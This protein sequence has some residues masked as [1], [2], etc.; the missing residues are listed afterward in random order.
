M[1]PTYNF[2]RY[3]NIRS[4]YTPT[5]L[6][7]GQRVAFLTDITGTP[8]VWSVDKDGGWPEQLTFFQEN[9]WT[10]GAAPDGNSLICS[11]DIGG[12]ENYQLYLVSSE[13]AEVRRITQNLDAIYHF[14]AW[15]PDG[16]HIAFSSNERDGL[17]FDVYIQD[18]EGDYPEIVYQSEGS[19]RVLTWS[20]EGR[21]LVLCNEISSANQPLHLLDLK[22]REVR[23][24]SP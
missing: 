23:Q 11:R 14:G 13:G 19:F 22:T 2:E 16:K 12:N 20:P 3:L 24:L 6:E 18:L 5:W 10:L 8:Q 1:S 4:A 15:S 17:H 21:K 9:V 7:G